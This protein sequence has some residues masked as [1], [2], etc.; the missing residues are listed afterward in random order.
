ME[1]LEN[2]SLGM[3]RGIFLLSPVKLSE[4]KAAGWTCHNEEVL[5]LPDG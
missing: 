2:T 3:P 5:A 1:N 4:E